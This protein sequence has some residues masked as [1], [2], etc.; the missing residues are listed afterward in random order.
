M[1]IQQ[2]FEN[3]KLASGFMPD[4]KSS[5]ERWNVLLEKT[6]VDDIEIVSSSDTQSHNLEDDVKETKKE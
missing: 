6:L 1:V 3:A 2:I 4:T 5:I